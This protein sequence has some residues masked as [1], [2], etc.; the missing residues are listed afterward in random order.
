MTVPFVYVRDLIRIW[1]I[2][3][4]SYKTE[5]VLPYLLEVLAFPCY[6]WPFDKHKYICA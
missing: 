5:S 4:G 2:L 6:F 3:Y 1:P